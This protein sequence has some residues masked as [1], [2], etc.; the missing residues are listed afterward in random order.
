MSGYKVC[1]WFPGNQRRATCRTLS[2]KQHRSSREAAETVLMQNPGALVRV[3]SPRGGG[4][5]VVYK[6]DRLY[7]EAKIVRG[8]T[9]NY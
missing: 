8:V 9:R 3:T 1:F 4:R 6:L 5:G 2:K 7:N